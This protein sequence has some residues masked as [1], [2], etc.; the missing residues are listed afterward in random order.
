MKVL[1]FNIKKGVYCFELGAFETDFHS[2]PAIEVIVAL[3]G[4]FSLSIVNLD[5]H[6]LTFAIVEKNT[7]HKLTN[8]HGKVKL[9]L[10]EHQDDLL[11]TILDEFHIKLF[12]S[13]TSIE[14]S[15]NHT[16]IFSKIY[17]RIHLAESRMFYDNRV[18]KCLEIFENK[19]IDYKTLM[20]ELQNQVHL[21]ESR[22]SHLFKADIGVSLKKYLVWCR[23]KNAIHTH[24]KN[25]ENLFSSSL[26]SGFY[27]QAH[28][29][30]SFKEMLG[31]SPSTVYNSR[32]LQN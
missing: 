21:S 28:L 32:M 12:Q 25:H 24:L 18:S 30:K 4:S 22:L 9:M 11:K 20:K 14:Q 15:I 19:D 7:P 23:L 2:H 16:Q 8:L 6:N 29:S 26:I 5:Y 3:E 17:D 13:F 10:V 1:D 31:I 27:D